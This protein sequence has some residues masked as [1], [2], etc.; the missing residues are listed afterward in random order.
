MNSSTLTILLVILCFIQ[1]AVSITPRSSSANA[2]EKCK[3]LKNIHWDDLTPEEQSDILES[4]IIGGAHTDV[5]YM[6]VR[7]GAPV[8]KQAVQWA[9]EHRPTERALIKYLKRK[10]GVKKRFEAFCQ[11]HGVGKCFE[12]GDEQLDMERR[13]RW[14]QMV[15]RTYG[16][17]L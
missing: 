12:E 17:S 16:R 9:K 3:P 10:M 5:V 2:K 14:D 11:R 8:T 7:C 13:Q 1:F 15:E 6:L 4:N